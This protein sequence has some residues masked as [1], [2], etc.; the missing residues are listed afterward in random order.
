MTAPRNLLWLVPLLLLVAYPLWRQPARLFLNPMTGAVDT[1]RPEEVAVAGRSAEMEGVF[2]S[3]SR[4]GREEWHIRAAHLAMTDNE[5]D[6]RLREVEV[7]LFGRPG[8]EKEPRLTTITSQAGR[9]EGPARLLTLSGGILLQTDNGYTMRSENLAHDG[10]RDTI[11]ASQG[12]E[13]TATGIEASGRA[14]HYNI[15]T[16]A[17]RLQDRVVFQTR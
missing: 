7:V 5:N 15:D 16:G 17:F 1:G 12:V 9:Y 4:A 2:I 3:Q 11:T 6:L 14:L 8:E 10:N 13:V